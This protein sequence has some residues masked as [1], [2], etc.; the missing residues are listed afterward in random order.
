M[1]AHGANVN[2]L[3]PV[4]T[5]VESEGITIIVPEEQAINAGL[6]VLLRVAWITLTVHSDLRAVGLTAAFSS[7]LSQS[8]ISCNV[9]SGAFHDHIFVPVEQARQALG[10][11]QTLQQDS[12]R[13]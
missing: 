2:A 5:V 1:L 9:M 12:V 7:A 6:A 11:L 13:E 4:A 8:G 10:V 3:S